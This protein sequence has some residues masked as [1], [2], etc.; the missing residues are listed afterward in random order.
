V[1]DSSIAIVGGGLSSA[2]F[3]KA[4]REGGG[5]APLRLI[6]ADTELPYHRP[7]LSKAYL[8]GEREAED[9][10][11]EKRDFYDGHGVE[12][13]L[14]TR[15]NSADIVARELELESGDRVPFGRLVIASGARPRPLGVPGEDMANVFKLRRLADSTAIKEAAQGAEHAVVVGA[16]FIGMEVTA[17][18]TQLGVHVTLL[19]RGQGLF[20]V[21]GA[22]P[23]SA[24]LS[25]LYQE[26]GVE[27]LL[28]EQAAALH[29][30]GAVRSVRTQSGRGLDADLV[31][32]GLG[33]A[34]WTDWLE[35]TRLELDNGIVVDERFR[36]NADGVY[37]VGD[38]ANFWD[39]VFG[40]R[41]RIEHWS[42]ANYQGAELGKLL[43]TGEGGYDIVSSFFS[44]VFGFSLRLHGLPE[45][46]DEVVVRGD[47]AERE[48]IAFYLGAGRFVAALTV[49]QPDEV[50]DGL[51]EL[52]RTQPPVANRAALS[53]PSVAIA[54]LV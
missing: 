2:R 21:L 53:D 36:T 13:S 18:L 10:L 32:L 9:T 42:N 46:S 41:R 52:L 20:E 8:R 14:A 48:A 49:G 4:Y 54:D 31:V 47:F 7:P 50:N 28:G 33:V 44:E 51:K 37:A 27:V 38:V 25:L 1:A 39:P 26:Q 3:V 40:R 45:A 11:V 5:D 16:G 29:G 23:L 6:S 15:V 19:H 24:Y 30:N 43:A 17:S 12:V 34:P 22:P 35:G